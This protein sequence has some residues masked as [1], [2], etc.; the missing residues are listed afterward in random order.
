MST[1]SDHDQQH[2]MNTGNDMTP[3]GAMAYGHGQVP[4]PGANAPATSSA[5]PR[6]TRSRT[7]AGLGGGSSSGVGMSIAAQS[8]EEKY[9]GKYRELKKKVRDIEMEN[10][11][12]QVKVLK[13]KRGIQRL[14]MER[15]D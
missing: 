8:E 1:A 11:K 5:M 14:R 12:L 3:P 4:A 15:A 2:Y 10:D 13:A 6:A 7:Q 9:E